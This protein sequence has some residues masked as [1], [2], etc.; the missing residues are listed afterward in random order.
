MGITKKLENLKYHIVDSTAY[1]TASYPVYTAIDTMVAGI[2]DDIS[3]NTRILGGVLTYGGLGWAIGKGRDLSKKMFKITDKTKERY[4]QIHDSLYLATINIPLGAG[5]YTL[6]G[7]TDIKKI[8]IGTGLG[9][10]FGLFM[11]PWIGY[12]VDSAR[13]LIGLDECKRKFYPKSIQKLGPKIKKGLAVALTAASIG[14]M[15]LMYAL[16]PNNPKIPETECLAIQEIAP[17]YH[18][19]KES[20]EQAIEDFEK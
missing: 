15:S 17:D 10:A 5:M 8:A 12:A 20:L 13:D 7:E 18:S 11:G 1:L 16:S 9:V 4:Q 19:P 14:I 3:I 6:A 2:A